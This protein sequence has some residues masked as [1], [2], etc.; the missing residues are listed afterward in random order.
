MP[1]STV[2]LVAEKQLLHAIIRL[3]ALAVPLL[4]EYDV[5]SNANAMKEGYGN[6]KA[7]LQAAL[8]SDPELIQFR[9]SPCVPQA[10]MRAFET[11][12]TFFNPAFRTQDRS[13][14]QS[15]LHPI[16]LS[17]ARFDWN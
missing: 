17:G 9:V 12:L 7:A 10:L 2:V 6:M 3:V 8:H 11:A 14:M 13:R 16:K 5:C 4:A 1:P 15:I